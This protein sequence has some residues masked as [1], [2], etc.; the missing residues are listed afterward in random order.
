MLS[1]L[2]FLLC[3]LDWV[4]VKVN[5][6]A[7]GIRWSLTSRLEDLVF[8]DDICLL[9]QSEMDMKM[10]FD[11]LVKYSSQ[12]A[13]KINVSKTKLMKIGTSMACS[14]YVG[15]EQ[16]GEVDCFQY[17]GSC[18]TTDGGAEEDVKLRIQK[19]R[20][21][22][23]MLGK[24]WKS[25][26]ISKNLKMR[27]F[28]TNCLSVLLY[29]CETWKVTNHI[30]SKLQVFINKCLRRIHKIY[31]PKV[32]SNSDL[33]K[34]AELEQVNTIVTRRKWKWI[35]HTLRRPDG[36]IARYSLDWNPQGSRRPGRP[37]TTWR[38]TVMK[39]VGTS[40]RCWKEVKVLARNRDAWRRYVDAL[41]SPVE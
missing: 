4:M 2:L 38:R 13:M 34:L 18:I 3:F 25:S 24:V 7:H 35:G 28:K 41:C 27:I 10:K 15:S 39:E 31:W 29:G 22:F 20:Q 40:G 1:P 23:G 12:V 36:D 33:W 26:Q 8:A 9:T 17:L 11:R 32:I 14:L 6:E 30:L 16:I 19:A 37:K 21:M 5:S